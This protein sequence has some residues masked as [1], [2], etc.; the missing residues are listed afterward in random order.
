MKNVECGMAGVH[1][2]GHAAF[3]IV[4]SWDSPD[5][6]TRHDRRRRF[7]RPVRPPDRHQGPPPAG[8]R[9][10]PP[11][12]GSDRDV[13][14]LQGH[15]PVGQPELLLVRRGL[16]LHE[17]DLRPRHP[18]RRLLLRP[19]GNRQ[20]LRRRGGARGRARVGTREP[21]RGPRTPAL[22]G[23]RPGRAGV[24]E[25]LRLGGERRRGIRRT[26][27][28]RCWA[29]ARARATGSRPSGPTSTAGT[30]S[31]SIPKWTTPSTATR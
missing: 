29:R 25:P 4:H 2:V 27:L 30:V 13:P 1:R 19:P 3:S 11:A 15:H 21:A 31:S 28:L 9:G 5:E 6:P 12:R 24:H 20:A 26:R 23:P 17:G 18:D 22:R 7:R 8:A 16:G 14:P 10:D